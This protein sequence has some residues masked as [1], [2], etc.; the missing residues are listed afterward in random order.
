ML[1]FLKIKHLWSCQPHRVRGFS[2]QT[3]E[4]LLASTP[5]ILYTWWRSKCPPHRH[6]LTGLGAYDANTYYMYTPNTQQDA[7]RQQQ[8]SRPDVFSSHFRYMRDKFSLGNEDLETYIYR[9]LQQGPIGERQE[10]QTLV[11]SPTLLIIY[12][13]HS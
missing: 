5:A 11:H 10:S 4:I 8:V 6:Q 7:S 9:V 13:S 12:L 2:L 3:V 1:I